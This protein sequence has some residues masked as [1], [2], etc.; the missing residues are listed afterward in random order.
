MEGVV[1]GLGWGWRVV[2]ELRWPVN[3]AEANISFQIANL[4]FYDGD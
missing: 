1:V 3:S 2:N 4:L